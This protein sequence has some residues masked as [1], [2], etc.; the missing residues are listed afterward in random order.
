MN[1]RKIYNEGYKAGTKHCE[2]DSC[3]YVQYS[4]DYVDWQE[5]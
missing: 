5:G 1:N 2:Q 4:T 3:P